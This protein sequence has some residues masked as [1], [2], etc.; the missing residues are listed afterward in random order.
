MALAGLVVGM[1]AAAGV[2]LGYPI[3]SLDLGGSDAITLDQEALA[4]TID[5]EQ[6]L[7]AQGDLPK[8][9][10][11]A[12]AAVADAVKL[13]G[14][15]Y[16]GDTVVPDA[17]VGEPLTSAFV[18]TTN[19]AFMISEAVK[20]KQQKDAGKYIK[21]LTRS[22]DLCEGQRY[23][24]GS[25]VDKVRL[26]ITNNR[27]DVPLELDYLTRTLTPVD[28]GTTRIVSYFQVGNFIVAIQYAGPANPT[29]TLMSKAE[30]EILYRVAPEQFSKTARVPGQKPVPSDTTTT[31]APDLVQPSPTSSP[32]TLA[33]TPPTFEPPTTTRPKR[34]STTRKAT[35]T[36]APATVPAGAPAG[37]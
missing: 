33:T 34:P 23:Y 24:T 7:V 29:K 9:Y 1:G 13:V 28:G 8:S 5:G 17:V 10:V 25:G 20:V 26:E 12:D 16:C 36:T 11:A 4:S 31:T 30:D 21:E 3:K 14:A 37:P 15:E 22:F 19:S 18:D 27:K 35:A 2:A 32:P 6:A